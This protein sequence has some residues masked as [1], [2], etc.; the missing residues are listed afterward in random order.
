[1]EARAVRDILVEG[2]IFGGGVNIIWA[3]DVTIRG[4][5]ITTRG[6]KSPAILI[7]GEVQRVSI[8]DNE[9]VAPA[10]GTKEAVSI[11]SVHGEEIGSDVVIQ[12]N[13]IRGPKN[14]G[15]VV[16]TMNRVV[17]T[18]NEIEG[19]IILEAEKPVSIRDFKVMDNTIRDPDTCLRLLGRDNGLYDVLVDGNWCRAPRFEDIRG[20]VQGVILGTNWGGK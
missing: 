10:D 1:M 11:T 15:V 8:T 6:D 17:I 3:R 20:D 18:D 12:G 14:K 2:N 9:L 19:S 13:R 5:Q 16:R 7:N 4:N